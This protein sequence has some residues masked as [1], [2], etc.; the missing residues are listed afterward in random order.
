M[1]EHMGGNVRPRRWR[2]KQDSQAPWFGLRQS[3][4]L[5]PGNERSHIFDISELELSRI[6][7]EAEIGSRHTAIR[8]S[9]LATV[10]MRT[11]APNRDM[12]TL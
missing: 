11:R 6:L 5:V 4:G 8:H 10:I 1:A 7:P 2:R 9:F 3:D 12:K